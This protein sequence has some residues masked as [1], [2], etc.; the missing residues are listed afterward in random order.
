[1][2]KILKL[3]F[4]MVLAL[5]VVAPPAFGARVWAVGD[6]SSTAVTEDDQVA[7]LIQAGS[8]D[9]FLYLGDVYETGTAS[10]YSLGYEPGYGR[11]KAIT[12]PTPGNHEWGNRASGYDAYWGTAYT[13]PHYY[14]FDLGGWHF[15][16][17]NSEEP[18]GEGSAQLSWLRGDL[19][20]NPGTCTIAFSHRPRYSASAHGD[21]ASMAPVFD[22]LTGH[23]TLAL[24]GHDH[25]YQRLK[26]IDGITN[27]VVGTGGRA[28][29]PVNSSDPRLAAF[30]DDSFG[31]LLLDLAPGR[32]DYRFVA[33]GGATLDQGAVSCQAGS[34]TTQPS[35]DAQAP[36]L[37]GLR[38]QRA[39][40]RWQAGPRPVLRFRLN[41]AASVKVSVS[42]RRPRRADRQVARFTHT[43]KVGRNKIRLA[44]RLSARLRP[45]LYRLALTATDAAGN[46]ADPASVSLR[47]L[48]RR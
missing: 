14:S 35:P 17:V 48:R 10:E 46:S 8:P 21:E 4:L 2:A 47:V 28:R 6:G 11:L 38:L 33:L 22:A 42:K 44:P 27:M 30:R 34:S 36:G 23:A 3:G 26:P 29:Y 1:M 40:L 13:N 7:G 32:A 45:G 39:K 24:F 43:G 18:H 9:A 37:F 16:S 41:E 25:S 19:A 31:A 5:A 12:K 15:V 20:R